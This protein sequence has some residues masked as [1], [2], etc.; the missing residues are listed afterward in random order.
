M[1]FS[2]P[3]GPG[4]PI[5]STTREGRWAFTWTARRVWFDRLDKITVRWWGRRYT[6]YDRRTWPWTA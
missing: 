2:L 5:R 3:P 6:I 4:K 1:G